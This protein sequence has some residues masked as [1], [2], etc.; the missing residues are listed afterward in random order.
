VSRRTDSLV[1]AIVMLIA[2]AGLGW[3]IYR[4]RMAGDGQA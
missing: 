3:V 2:V 4:A 1:P